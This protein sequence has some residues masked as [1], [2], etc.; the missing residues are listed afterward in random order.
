MTKAKHPPAKDRRDIGKVEIPIEV[1]IE[2]RLAHSSCLHVE[3][4]LET[5]SG[6]ADLIKSPSHIDVMGKDPT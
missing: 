1:L 6:L 2:A 4:A 5:R 3:A